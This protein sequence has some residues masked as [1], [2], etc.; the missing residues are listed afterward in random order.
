MALLLQWETL[1]ILC[2][3]LLVPL[4]GLHVQVAGFEFW[5]GGRLRGKGFFRGMSCAIEAVSV[6][7]HVNFL[8][9]L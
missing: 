1:L 9:H 7:V 2:T 6:N 4:F 8:S 5:G 3:M